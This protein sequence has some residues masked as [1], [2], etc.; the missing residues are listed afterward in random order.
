[1]SDA[2]DPVSLRTMKT[3]QLKAL[4]KRELHDA[5]LQAPIEYLPWIR[6]NFSVNDRERAD[7][8]GIIQVRGAAANT[9]TAESTLT[10]V[11][12]TN[13]LVAK[14]SDLADATRSLRTATWWMMGLTTVLAVAA[15]VAIFISLTDW[16]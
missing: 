1:M 2:V 15:L 7:I 12:A 8:D 4:G 9:Q 11:H 13:A 6:R 14:T 16:A 5:L 10:L 3:D